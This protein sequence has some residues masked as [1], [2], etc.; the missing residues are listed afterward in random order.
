MADR[1]ER[2]FAPLL[3]GWS[4]AAA[5]E[6]GDVVRASCCAAG[7]RWAF[8]SATMAGMKCDACGALLRTMRA[9]VVRRRRNLRGGGA[10]AGRRSGESPTMS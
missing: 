3:L 10:A 9:G 6:E 1:W 7:R 5:R 8:S 4:S 2:R